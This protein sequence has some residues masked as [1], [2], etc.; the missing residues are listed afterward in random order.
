M[1]DDLAWFPLAAPC[2]RCEHRPWNHPCGPHP[3]YRKTQY[4]GS[5]RFLERPRTR[6][7]RG[8]I[9]QYIIYQQ[10]AEV[11][12]LQALAGGVGATC[13]FPTIVSR[14]H[15]LRREPVAQAREFVIFQQQDGLDARNHPGTLPQIGTRLASARRWPQIRHG[16]GNTTETGAPG[17]S[18]DIRGSITMRCEWSSAR[19]HYPTRGSGEDSQ[20]D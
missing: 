13:R 19:R 9:R 7:E 1:L 5:A 20:N 6:I 11:V 8:T 15:Q 14:W 18:F 16:W 10:N 12:N 3:R 4:R 17:A 2:M